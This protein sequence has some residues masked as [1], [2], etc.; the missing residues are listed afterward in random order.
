LIDIQIINLI[1]GQAQGI[2]KIYHF[3]ECDKY[4]ALVME[5]LGPSLEKVFRE[6]EHKFSVKTTTKLAIQLVDLMEYIH[7]RRVI[8]RNVKP[9]NF[10][11]GRPNTKYANQLYVIG[12]IHANVYMNESQ[13][14][15]PKIKGM[16]FAGTPRYMSLRTHKGKEQSRRDDLESIGHMLIYFIRGKL[17]WQGLQANNDAEKYDKIYRVKKNTKLEE[18]CDD[19]PN[20]YYHYMLYVRTLKFVH[21]PNYIYLKQM[22]VKLLERL[23]FQN[24]DVYDWDERRQSLVITSPKTTPKA[25]KK[26]VSFDMNK[27]SIS[28]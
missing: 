8:F 16:P 23:G 21:E 14:H 1:K 18:L 11:L 7:S 22:F 12:F 4:N 2:P 27:I 24:D 26:S 5:L 20:E 9:E 19:M 10:C 17:P 28:E 6:C 13:E 3:G 15:I 25:T